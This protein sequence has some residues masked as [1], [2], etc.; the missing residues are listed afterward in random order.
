M[1]DAGTFA[2]PQLG[3]SVLCSLVSGTSM[4]MGRWGDLTSEG[5][6]LSSSTG[7]MAGLAESLTWTWEDLVSVISAVTDE[8]KDH[9]RS[10]SGVCVI[11]SSGLTE[12]LTIFSI[13]QALEVTNIY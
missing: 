2:V 6:S 1:F 13:E 5:A 3:R 4:T 9:T 12:D 10:L 11:I 8:G 7:S